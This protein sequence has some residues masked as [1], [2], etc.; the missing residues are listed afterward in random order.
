[1]EGG[2]EGKQTDGISSPQKKYVT[3]VSPPKPFFASFVL[4]IDKKR[5]SGVLGA[6]TIT[7]TAIKRDI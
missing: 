3:T 4:R 1:M 7:T 5:E 6:D 2:G